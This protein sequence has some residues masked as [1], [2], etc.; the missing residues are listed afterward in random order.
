VIRCVVFDFDGTLVDSNEIKRTAFLDAAAGSEGGAKMMAEVLA[1][2]AAGDRYAVFDRF[3]A[4]MRGSGFVGAS[5]GFSAES[6]A[7]EY[8]RACE[9]RIA[10]AAEVPG[11]R[12]LLE[13]LRERGVA[14]HVCSATPLRALG[15][16]VAA[17][18]LSPLVDGLWGGPAS[19]PENL[20]S[21]LRE[22]GVGPGEAL[23]VG[24]SDDDLRC[25]EEVGCAF[26][27]VV[28]GASRF[29]RDPAATVSDLWE[30]RPMLEEGLP[31]RVPVPG[32]PAGEGA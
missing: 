13:W 30:L 31:R 8:T 16:V 23:L 17:R 24:D 18:G 4:R 26:V 6:L 25:A 27:G 3:V 29:T 32:A 10:A 1:D 11:A 19:K 12:R 7:D 15:P 28:L 5:P 21:I 9:R 22:A 20:A 14:V 2:P